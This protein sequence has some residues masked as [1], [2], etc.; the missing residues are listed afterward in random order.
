MVRQCPLPLSAWG[1]RLTCSEEVLSVYGLDSFVLPMRTC[2]APHTHITSV[3][4]PIEPFPQSAQR[5]SFTQMASSDSIM[6]V[7]HYIRTAHFWY[8]YVYLEM[9]P[10]ICIF[11]SSVQYSVHYC[12]SQTPLLLSFGRATGMTPFLA[13]PRLPLPASSVF[14]DELRMQP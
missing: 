12:Q 9:A 1:T 3:P 7:M 13:S 4:R 5:F 2:F 8:Y 14:P 10:P 11:M 6:Q